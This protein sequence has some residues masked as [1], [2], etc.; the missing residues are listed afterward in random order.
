MRCLNSDFPLHLQKRQESLG[1]GAQRTKDQEGMSQL[2]TQYSACGPSGIANS[3]LRDSTGTIGGHSTDVSGGLVSTRGQKNISTRARIDIH[4]HGK[5][6]QRGAGCC[7]PDVHL[8][9]LSA[10]DIP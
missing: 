8:R 1:V 7:S 5:R 4:Y 2:G 3:R 6:C 10:T 9:L